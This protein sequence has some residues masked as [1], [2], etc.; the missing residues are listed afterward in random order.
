M[1][2]TVRQLK[3]LIGEATKDRWTGLGTDTAVLHRHEPKRRV[4]ADQ[5][6]RLIA[7]RQARKA[8]ASELWNAASADDRTVVLREEFDGFDRTERQRMR[9]MTFE[10]LVADFISIEELTHAV[11]H[12]LPGDTVD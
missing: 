2:I 12:W 6:S 5:R 8:R 1:K 4:S 9:D 10:Q 3:Q 7:A 11:L